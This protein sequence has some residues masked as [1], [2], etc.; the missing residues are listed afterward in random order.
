[1][2]D[3]SPLEKVTAAVKEFIQAVNDEP[4]IVRGAVVC[5]ETMAFDE[6]GDANYTVN[7]TSL[8]ETSMAETIGILDIA[9][10]VVR[11]DIASD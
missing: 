6:D 5:W 8:P 3:D 11:E 9:M 10:D 2:N 7:Y 1:M 4:V